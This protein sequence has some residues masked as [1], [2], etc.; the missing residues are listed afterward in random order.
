MRLVLLVLMAF[1]LVLAP[2]GPAGA[3]EW[4]TFSGVSSAGAVG[5]ASVGIP[6]PDKVENVSTRS[7]KGGLALDNAENAIKRARE[8]FPELIRG[9]EKELRVD[10]RDDQ[11]SGGSYW[12]LRWDRR[13]SEGM[14]DY[15]DIRLDAG[16]GKLSA[17]SRQL[18]GYSGLKEGKVITRDEAKQVALSFIR[19]HH[20][21]K[22]AKMVP[23]T[24]HQVWSGNNDLNL[25]YS[26]RWYQEIDGIPLNDN[27]INVR[28]DALTGQ[29]LNFSCSWQDG[30]PV[31]AGK[32]MDVNELTEQVTSKLALYPAYVVEYKANSSTLSGADLVYKLNTRYFRFSAESG[33][34]VD[35]RGHEVN[36]NEAGIFKQELTPVPAPEQ[37]VIKQQ[38]GQYFSRLKAQNKA[39]EFFKK[40]GF[41]GRAERSGSGSSSGPGYTTEYWS[42]RLVTGN[43]PD[44]SGSS[45]IDVSINTTTGEVQRYQNTTGDDRGNEQ[46]EGITREKAIDVARDFLKITG[47]GSIKDMILQ[48]ESMDRYPQGEIPYYNFT[49]VRLVNGVPYTGDS[50]RVTVSRY[51]GEVREFY[52]QSRPVKSFA[53]TKDILS[54]EAAAK[55]L[56]Q[57]DP[58]KLSYD[59]IRD[60][61]EGTQK[62][63]LV[64]HIDYGYGIDAHTGEKY[65]I[66][67]NKGKAGSYQAKLQNHWARLPLNLLAD[68]GLLPAPEEFEP[69]AA[70]SRR[71]GL[72]VLG[73]AGSRYYHPQH[74]LQSPFK[75]V[76]DS[77]QDITSFMRAV[78]TGIIEVGGKLYPDAPL[79]REDLAVWMVNVLGYKEVAGA[80]ISMTVDFAD[81][82]S[83]S[84]GKE[85]YVAITAGL[86][87]MNGN[88]KGSFRPQKPVTW[89]EL[90]SVVI[91]AA[92]KLK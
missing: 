42:Y 78:D 53:S 85:N 28:V 89:G 31:K 60:L 45:Q 5:Q 63:L 84:A 26:F 66:S 1:V 62:T 3:D 92:P 27:N 33:K 35:N 40:L 64:Y 52:R 76:A 18:D 51:S 29:V 22:L 8:L 73:V 81:T 2:G 82:A 37:R 25:G 17:F 43:A 32:A 68:S 4:Q 15:F 75:D 44:Y 21:D 24:D 23:D 88:G 10:Y 71:E 47:S 13:V 83:I 39:E 80:P 55:A 20:P 87:L 74:P 6:V 57:A 49:W 9:K 12:S 58:F 30:T 70:V 59:R 61:E 46:K 48:Q 34:P 36:W 41:E 7:G 54:R 50:V 90:A 79:T 16:N 14:P 65:P 38:N 11:Y 72:K 69:N 77:D 86:G 19:R 67:I 91:K 56:Q